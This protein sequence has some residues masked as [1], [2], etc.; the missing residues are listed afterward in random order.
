MFMMTPSIR[1]IV[2]QALGAG[3]WL[4]TSIKRWG[5]LD[6]FQARSLEGPT[7]SAEHGFQCQQL[8]VWRLLQPRSQLIKVFAARQSDE[9]TFRSLAQQT[10]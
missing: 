5:W 9:Q 7:S 2:R 1:L 3:A 4:I 10:I 8:I 6:R